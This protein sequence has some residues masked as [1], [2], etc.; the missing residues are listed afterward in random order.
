M[1]PLR[2]HPGQSHHDPG[3]SVSVEYGPTYKEAHQARRKERAAPHTVRVVIRL[4]AL[5]VAASII[6]VLAHATGVWFT[7][8]DVV[9]QRPNG[10]RQRAWP[11]HIDLWPTWVMLGAAIIAIFIQ[12]VSLLTLCGGVSSLFS[13]LRCQKAAHLT[14]PTRSVVSANPTCTT[15]PSFSAPRSPSPHG[16]PRRSTLSSRTP[17]E[18]RIGTCGP[19]RAPTSPSRTAKCRSRPCASKWYV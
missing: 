19:G 4:L 8:R 3:P 5:V 12:I 15:G 18:R 11:L 7:T 9:Q 14:M 2:H 16:P 1:E 6:G 10:I 17:R 13:P